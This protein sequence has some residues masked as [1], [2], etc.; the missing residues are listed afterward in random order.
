MSQS[1]PPQTPPLWLPHVAMAVL[2]GCWGSAAVASPDLGPY[3]SL[4]GN[5]VHQSADN[6]TPQSAWGGLGAGGVVFHGGA[7]DWAITTAMGLAASGPLDISASVQPRGRLDTVQVQGG[8]VWSSNIWSAHAWG[9][10]A[11][12]H[13]LSVGTCASCSA[14]S[15]PLEGW[16]MGPAVGASGMM[17]VRSSAH[18]KMGPEL[19]GS[20]AFFPSGQRWEAHLGFAIAPRFP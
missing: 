6:V 16:V 5:I 13:A 1:H 4:S 3:A 18:G 17:A 14:K 9:G 20:G 15:V 11:S 12:A 8:P 2:V 19:G 10:W 7:L